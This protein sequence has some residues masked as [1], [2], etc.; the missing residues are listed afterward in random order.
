M[1][2]R[3]AMVAGVRIQAVLAAGDGADRVVVVG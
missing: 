1:T 2:A 3:S